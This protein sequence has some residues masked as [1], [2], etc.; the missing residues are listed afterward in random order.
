MSKTFSNLKILPNFY[1][2]TL[3]SC[4]TFTLS[5]SAVT[6]FPNAIQ[7]SAQR[8]LLRFISACCCASLKIMKKWNE[9]SHLLS[10]EKKIFHSLSGGGSSQEQQQHQYTEVN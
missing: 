8:P 2:M 10:A 6:L 5:L 3:L 4:F 1:Q 7:S 9:K